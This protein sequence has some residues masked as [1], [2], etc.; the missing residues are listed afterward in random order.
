VKTPHKKFY[1]DIGNC[2]GNNDKIWTL[3]MNTEI[4]HKSHVPMLLLHGYA[5]ALAFWLLNL[6]GFLLLNYEFSHAN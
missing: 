5:S 3:A 4:D 1:I 6:D 2:V